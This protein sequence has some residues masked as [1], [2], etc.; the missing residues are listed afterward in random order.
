MEH[1]PRKRPQT[2]ATPT[3]TALA[4]PFEC[5]GFISRKSDSKSLPAVATV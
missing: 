4:I 3:A 1:H 2:L 5:E